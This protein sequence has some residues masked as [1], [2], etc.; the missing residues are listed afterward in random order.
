MAFSVWSPVYVS[1]RICVCLLV[2]VS[3]C[4]KSVFP[5]VAVCGLAG[6][7]R[8]GKG[9][10]CPTLGPAIE[11]IR[12]LLELDAER[13]VPRLGYEVNEVRRRLRPG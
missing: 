2:P 3:L 9:P 8:W 6:R 1:I 7:L 4:M 11:R 10:S 5:W 13:L 12:E